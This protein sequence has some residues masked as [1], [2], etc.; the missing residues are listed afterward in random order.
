MKKKA[1]KKIRLHRETLRNLDSGLEGVVGGI[2]VG[3]ICAS[4]NP[5]ICN[6]ASGCASCIDP[7]GPQTHTCPP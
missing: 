4:K 3:V 1:V 6:P 7:C 2:T 5:T